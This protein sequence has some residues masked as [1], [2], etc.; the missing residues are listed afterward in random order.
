MEG[1]APSLRCLIEMKAAI[2]NGEPARAG[3]DKYL[4]E[5]RAHDDFQ[6]AVRRFLFSWDQGGDWRSMIAQVDGSQRRALLELLAASL[7]GQPIL[8]QLDELQTE[9][10]IA[11]D[12]E[13][14][15]HMDLLPIR[16]LFPLLFLQFPAFLI[17]LFG[18]LLRKF[19][20]E[21]GK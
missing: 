16:M 5:I 17:L 3:I 19:L 4:G 18:P 10:Q 15:R 20:E 12:I 21:L 7:M 9:I 6:N 1:L 14:R 8:Q 2:Q 13:I 11:A